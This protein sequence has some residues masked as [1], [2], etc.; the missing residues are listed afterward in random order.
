[1]AIEFLRHYTCKLAK[2]HI[3]TGNYTEFWLPLQQI[4]V[5]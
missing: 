2:I 1:M 3:T 4:C 5:M